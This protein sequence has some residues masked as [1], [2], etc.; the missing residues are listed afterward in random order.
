MSDLRYAFRQLRHHPGFTIV[1]VLT[2]GLGIGASATVFSLVQGVL[3]TPPPYKD[4]GRLMLIKP[5]RSDGQR[6]T[7]GWPAAQWLDWQTASKSF[8]SIAAYGWTFN[9]LVLPDGS[10][11]VEGM[12]VTQEY[13]RL[14]GIQP[15]LGRSFVE[16]ETTAKPASAIILGHDLWQRRFNADPH[17]IGQSVQISRFRQPL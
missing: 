7:Q 17:I 15:F 1:A 13:F 14:A 10:E 8:D 5:I 16:S 6:Y 2:L 9:F 4:P 3:L 12:W 11:S